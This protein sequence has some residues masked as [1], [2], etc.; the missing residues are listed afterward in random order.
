LKIASVIESGE[1]SLLD[2]E[3]AS[4][5]GKAERR[6]KVYVAG[7]VDP[8]IPAAIGRPHGRNDGVGGV[9]DVRPSG[10]DGEHLAPACRHDFKEWPSLE[11]VETRLEFA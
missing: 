7:I 11:R 6:A 1:P 8:E 5:S 4:V 10:C 3:S 9:V 2:E